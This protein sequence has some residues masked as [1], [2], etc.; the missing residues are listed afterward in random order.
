LAKSPDSSEPG[1]SAEIPLPF[2]SENRTRNGNEYDVT[3][4]GMRG[5]NCCEQNMKKN[6]KGRRGQRKTFIPCYLPLEVWGTEILQV[7]SDP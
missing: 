3:G 4:I 6:L 1:T 2:H 5:Y 7:G